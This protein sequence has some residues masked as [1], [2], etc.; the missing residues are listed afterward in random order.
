MRS[1]LNSGGAAATVCAIAL[2]AA[3]PRRMDRSGT[4]PHFIHFAI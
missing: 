4:R 3:L 2:L 1:G